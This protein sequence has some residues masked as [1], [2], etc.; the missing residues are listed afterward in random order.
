MLPVQSEGSRV[1]QNWRFWRRQR[2]GPRI[3][4]VGNQ[5][6]FKVETLEDVIRV[7]PLIQQD[8]KLLAAGLIDLHERMR[9]VELKLGIKAKAKQGEVYAPSR[10]ILKP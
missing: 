2:K 7:L 8:G 5:V 4:N 10:E 9:R 6:V 1:K 3:E